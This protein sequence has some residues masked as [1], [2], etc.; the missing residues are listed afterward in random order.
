MI[1]LILKIFGGEAGAASI[2]KDLLKDDSWMV[3]LLKKADKDTINVICLTILA[4]NSNDVQVKMTAIRSIAG[5]V[6]PSQPVLNPISFP[7]GGSDA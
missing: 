7:I 3:E 4:M 5:L 6:G 1:D 2:V